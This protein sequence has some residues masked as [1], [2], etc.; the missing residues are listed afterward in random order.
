MIFVD[1]LSTKEQ[2]IAAFIEKSGRIISFAIKSLVFAAMIKF[3]PVKLTAA[4]T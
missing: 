2:F 4:K 3:V 1:L